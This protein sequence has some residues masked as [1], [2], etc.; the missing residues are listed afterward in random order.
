MME[1]VETKLEKVNRLLLAFRRRP[2]LA[3]VI[4]LVA[5]AVTLLNQHPIIGTISKSYL[6]NCLHPN[7]QGIF[8]TLLTIVVVFCA[9]NLLDLFVLQFTEF[10]LILEMANPF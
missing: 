2:V 6:E 8:P 4:L 5:S 3:V 1:V 7:Y 9:T 10:I